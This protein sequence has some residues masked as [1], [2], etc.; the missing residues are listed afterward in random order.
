M[1]DVVELV[2]ISYENK[3]KEVFCVLAWKDLQNML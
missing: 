2:M 3:N 1:Q